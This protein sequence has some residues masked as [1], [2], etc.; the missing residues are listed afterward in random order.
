MLRKIL[1]SAVALSMVAGPV[2]L[3]QGNAEQPADKPAA[4]KRLP[5]GFEALD[6]NK[7]GFI[8]P[9]EFAKRRIDALKSADTDGDGV[10]SQDELAAY[11]QKRD[12][13]R[14]ARAMSRM[15]D[16]DGDGKVTIE[17]LEKQ[18]AKR[19]ALMDTNDDGKLSPEELQRAHR[20]MGPRHPGFGPHGMRAHH[21]GWHGPH[22]KFA[23]HGKFDP[24][25][26]ASPA[27]LR[28]AADEAPAAAPSEQ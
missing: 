18:N 12:L 4:E 8:S 13:E 17:E 23:P 27:G 19:L 21:R 2:A 10:L 1:M 5:R 16:I 28:G 6:A 24:H 20:F 9:D 26:K 7:D 14:R 22:G 25:G 15:L 3:A 11:I